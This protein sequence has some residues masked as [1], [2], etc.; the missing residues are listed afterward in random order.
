GGALA[1]LSC[2][3]AAVAGAL[4]HEGTRLPAIFTFVVTASDITMIGV[5]APFW[6]LV[7]GV[8][9]LVVLRFGTKPAA[10]TPRA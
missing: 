8:G 9:M 7:G 3:W 4:V 2:T 6:G 5:G 10:A 1:P